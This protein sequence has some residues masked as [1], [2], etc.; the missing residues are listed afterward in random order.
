MGSNLKGIINEPNPVVMD[1]SG[2]IIVAKKD[3]SVQKPAASQTEMLLKQM[4]DP[5]QLGYGAK[6]AFIAVPQKAKVGT[7][8]QD[9]ISSDGVT[10]VTNYVIK[11]INGNDAVVGISGT[12]NRDTKMEM[13]GMEI[14][15]K[16]TGTFTGE[17]T[18]DVTTGVISKNNLTVD[19]KG[20]I[21]VMGQD[22]PTTI[23][24]TSVT[25]VKMM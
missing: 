20:T 10:R 13:Q 7:A 18:V 14:G 12:E 23:K 11:E 21:S 9:S 3:T 8:W 24:A 17:Q 5:E 4:G 6:I 15:T 25:T 19:A 2:N 1:K 16:T 22:I